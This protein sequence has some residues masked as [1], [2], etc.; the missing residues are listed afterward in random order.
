MQDKLIDE[1]MRK[2]EASAQPVKPAKHGLAA[3]EKYKKQAIKAGKRIDSGR[4]TAERALHKGIGAGKKIDS[5]LEKVASVAGQVSQILGEDSAPGELVHQVGA[6]AGQG[7]EKLHQA[8]DMAQTGKKFLHK[9]HEIFRQGLEAAQG[10]LAKQAA[11][12]RKHYLEIR[13]HLSQ[14]VKGLHGLD[15]GPEPP[16]DRRHAPSGRRGHAH[17]DPVGELI[18]GILDGNDGRIHVDKGAA[19]GDVP[20]DDLQ[21]VDPAALET[22]LGSGEGVK[23]FSEDAVDQLTD[24]IVVRSEE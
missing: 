22:W 7:H 9:G 20:V 11:S 4:T 6:G 1:A 18:D 15:A 12:A 13:A 8:L 21:E 24:G 14:F 17:H 2:L 3:I 23:L 5:G 16:H 10:D 19:R